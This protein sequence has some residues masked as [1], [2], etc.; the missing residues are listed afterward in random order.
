MTAR[1]DA[2]GRIVD[3]LTPVERA[4]LAARILADA[5]HPQTGLPTPPDAALLTALASAVMAGLERLGR[6]DPG[7]ACEIAAEM[8]EQLQAWRPEALAPGGVNGCIRCD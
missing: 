8:I 4:Q 6:L 7:A 2:V 5:A 3:G 1:L